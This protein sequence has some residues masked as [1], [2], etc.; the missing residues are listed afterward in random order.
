MRMD[1]NTALPPRVEWFDA[2]ARRASILCGK[3]IVFLAAVATIVAWA[4]T[5]PLFGF[6]DTWQLVI[7][8]GT[9]IVTFLM[10]FLIQNTQNRDAL[11]VQIKLAEL[12]IAA[13][14]TQ[15]RLANAEELSEQELEQLHDEFRKKATE[16]GEALSLRRQKR[17]PAAEL[18]E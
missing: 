14:G 17:Q 9:T 5:G 13:K 4:V 15:N 18:A 2:F 3:P 12:I 7:N 11:A 6:S 8:T 16:A 10:V 1:K